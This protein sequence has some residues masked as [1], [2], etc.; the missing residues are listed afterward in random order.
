MPME[1]EWKDEP[2]LPDLEFDFAAMEMLSQ[3]LSP[4]EPALSAAAEE[5][6]LPLPP[7]A[8]VEA[9][10]EPEPASEPETE[11]EPEVEVAVEV[12]T[13]PA[14]FP[15][16]EAA[17]EVPVDDTGWDAPLAALIAPR[18]LA[19]LTEPDPETVRSLAT[20]ISEIEEEI[21]RAPMTSVLQEKAAEPRVPGVEHV[22]FTLGGSRYAAP[23]LQVLAIDRVPPVTPIPNL[24]LFVK[25]VTNI[26]GDIVA[27][28]DLRTLLGI[29]PPENR[30]RERMMIVRPG[31]SAPAAALVVDDVTGIASVPPGEVQP[32]SES[33][34]AVIA[35]LL[36]GVWLRED[37]LVSVV[38]F[39]RVFQA[40]EVRQ[41]TAI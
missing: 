13:T 26:R 10:S 30:E 25:G 35:P 23:L 1:P 17:A 4:E 21:R 28:L 32:V 24:P 33:L 27:L 20:V 3:V 15:E 6:A 22:V 12:E 38:E 41:L 18:E 16:P 11:P 8:A 9:T 7:S 37:S 31:P 2:L 36:S 5:P 40:P 29:T 14:P 34:D 19:A 39:S